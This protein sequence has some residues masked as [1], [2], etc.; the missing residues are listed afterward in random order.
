M[1]IKDAIEYIKENK[2]QFTT[3]ALT[4]ELKKSG[5]PEDEIRA[6]FKIVVQEDRE[7][8]AAL[9]V[10]MPDIFLNA[11]ADF[12]LGIVGGL[13]GGIVI[14]LITFEVFSSFILLS[15]AIVIITIVIVYRFLNEKYYYLAS[16]LLLSTVFIIAALFLRVVRIF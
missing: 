5:Y 3:H 4:E 1:A 12:V 8:Y 15:N 13:V 7:K 9:N 16:G 2:L 14:I 11:K 6:A 10:A